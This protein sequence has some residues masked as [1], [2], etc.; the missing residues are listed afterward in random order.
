MKLLSY[1]N[2]TVRSTAIVRTSGF[3]R[4]GTVE[5]G[6]LALSLGMGVLLLVICGCGARAIPLANITDKGHQWVWPFF[7]QNEQPTVLAFWNTDEMACLRNVPALQALDARGGSVELVT[8]VTGR[9]RLE[10]DQWLRS[11]RIRYPVLLDLEEKL[12]Q[13]L[14]VHRYPTFLF[15]DTKGKEIG[16]EED[17]R[18]VKKWFDSPRWLKKAGGL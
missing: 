10:I 4:T 3:V 14:R 9:D 17:I 13:K 8:V 7:V 15:L 6:R 2:L 18:L 11:K 5:T 12:S 16:R 1:P